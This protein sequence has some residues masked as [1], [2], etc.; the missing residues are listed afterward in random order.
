MMDGSVAR[1][2]GRGI[3]DIVVNGHQV[4]CRALV[5]PSISKL[6][7]DMLLGMDVIEA[8]GGVWLSGSNEIA[9][10]V[11]GRKQKQLVCAVGT[12]DER[13]S[14]DFGKGNTTGQSV[15]ISSEKQIE[16]KDFTAR[17]DGTG[18][19]IL[20][21]WRSGEEPD[22]LPHQV[23]EYDSAREHAEEVD[24]ELKEWYEKG[25]LVRYN[26][27]VRGTLPVM[28]V[29]QAAK[30]KATPVFDFRNLNTYIS[31]HTEDSQVC[32]QKL[33]EWRKWGESIAIVDLRKAYLQIGV[34]E[35]LWPYQVIRW[36][37]ETFCLTRLGFGLNI[38]PKAMR[39]ILQFVLQTDPE[40][41]EATDSY[42]DDIV[43]DTSKVPVE[44]VVQVLK[45]FG[46]E[47]KEPIVLEGNRL[48]GLRVVRNN[49]NDRLQWKRDGS[50]PQIGA[51]P[52]KRE[53]FSWAGKL[54]GHLP[55]CGWL[56]PACSMLKRLASTVNWDEKVDEPVRKLVKQMEKRLL[57]ED[58]AKGQ[59]V[60]APQGEAKVWCDASSIAVG[61]CVEIGGSVV[62]D[63]C[64]LRKANDGAHINLAELDAVVNSMNMAVDWGLNRFSIMTDSATVFK[65]LNDALRGAAPVRTQGQ[66]GL[67]VR[68]RVFLIKQIVEELS[69]DVTA[70]LVKSSQN[71]ADVLTRVP[72]EWM[73]RRNSPADEHIVA[74]AN[75]EENNNRDSLRELHEL[76][77]LGVKRTSF[78][79]KKIW[80]KNTVS[81]EQ[82][83]A[84]VQSCAVCSSIDPSPVKWEKGELGVKKTWERLAIDVT[85]ISAMKF[86]TLVDCG[87]GRFAIW[88]RLRSEGETD[89]C[90][91]LRS[92]FDEFGWP[93]QVLL[94]NYSTF[95]GAAVRSLFSGMDVEIVFRCVNRPSGNGIVE[96]CHRTV[97]RMVARTGRQVGEMLAWY[98]ST[99]NA[100]GIVPASTMFAFK[101]RLPISKEFMD[102][103]VISRPT[104]IQQEFKIGD[105]VFTKPAKT[106]CMTRWNKGNVTKA[107][108]GLQI[109]VDGVPYHVSHVRR[110]PQHP[111]MVIEPE[112]G[113][114]DD[115]PIEM[116][117]SDSERSEKEAPV[118]RSQR[119]H[120][121]PQCLN[122]YVCD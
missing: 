62:E 46:L 33:R 85:H 79:A 5:A 55:V 72:K 122:D 10:G 81:E 117:S 97:K 7:V 74:V 71:K 69:L 42:V 48:L 34:E 107:L 32:A 64:W 14:D 3:V 36:N 90:V 57:F 80:G 51:N 77:H 94:D 45:S 84:V 83:R 53:I 120:H 17:F 12:S 104:N 105:A 52:S 30:G 114:V 99:P 65:W 75:A 39:C 23:P 63:A 66:N 38:A 50:V 121:S 4:R 108:D 56:R 37:G 22:C 29:V 2:E 76:H 95:R 41:A 100:N 24:V 67:L 28:A 49:H 21:K 58:P 54:V 118:R 31:S 106:T 18:W 25:W 43:V 16:D 119:D 89:V 6:G 47:A 86:L 116:D 59:W 93:H 88:R 91:V 101:R 35:K 40:V 44:R 13:S 87:P 20:W 109:E 11:D 103:Q 92:I 19:K 15:G 61:V 78:L 27:P 70:S 102:G 82:V 68:R 73:E 113:T 26:G 98:N 112:N 9:F 115:F 1:V 110:N 96:R 8:L 60:V 111:D